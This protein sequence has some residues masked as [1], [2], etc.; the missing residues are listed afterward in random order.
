MAT[1]LFRGFVF[2]LSAAIA[3]LYLFVAI[4]RLL[5]GAAPDP[6]ERALLDHAIRLAHLKP[7]YGEPGPHPVSIMPGFPFTVSVLVQS[8]GPAMWEPRLVTLLASLA[9]GALV[10]VAVRTE[11]ESWTLG[12]AGAA[13]AFAG[14]GVL[15]GSPGVARPEPLTLV[16]VFA[17]LLT[18]R[19]IDGALG[20]IVAALLMAAACLTQQFAM[21]FA[22]GGLM[23]LA[24]Q[25]RRRVAPF[26][27]AFAVFAG[28]G[29]IAL[30]QALG[31]W[32]NFYASDL[33]LAAMR[34]D[35]AGFV[36]LAGDVV[37]GRMGILVSAALLSLALPAPPW[38]GTSGVW[39]W[40]GVAALVSGTIASQSGEI[41][42]QS[43]M[44]CVTA[45]ALL[46]PIAASKVA[47]HLAA[48]PGSSRLGGERA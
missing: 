16:L 1:R 46:G 5:S 17:A 33:P 11:T 6:I 23:Y 9:L 14:S 28:G 45:F 15:A 2:T 3:G 42:P 40:G 36:H 20:A 19:D 48:W 37:L 29:Y 31:S 22:A 34:L 25:Q 4:R 13:L 24:I 47:E 12:I 30:S 8:L 7:L 39:F 26:L 44:P 18:L 41:G 10:L 43:L 21:C 35:P 27:L 38:R 32:F